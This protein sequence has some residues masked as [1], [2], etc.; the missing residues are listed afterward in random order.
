MAITALGF[1]IFA[2]DHVSETTKKV[3]RS[4]KQLAIDV[5]AANVRVE[6]ATRSLA[7]AETKFGKSSLEARDASVKL[8]QAQLRLNNSTRLSGETAHKTTGHFRNLLAAV[9]GLAITEGLFEFGKK[10]VEAF[11]EA[12]GAQARLSDA[13][14]KFPLL[15]NANIESFRQLNDELEKKTEADHNATAS[16]EATLAQFRL[17][18]TQV[19]NLTPLLVDYA[20]KTGKDLPTAA[21]D[22]GKAILGQGRALKGS[23]IAFHDTGTVAGNYAE[24]MDALKAKV[25]GFAVVQGK[26]A[27]GQVVIFQNRLHSLEEE[28][29][30]QLLPVLTATGGTL[31]TVAGF[32]DRNRKVIG[33]LV[34]G[35]GGLALAILAVNAAARATKSVGSFVNSI[36]SVGDSGP[37]LRAGLSSVVGFLGGPWGAALTVGGLALGL[38]ARK[39]S[40]ARQLVDELKN[41]LNQETGAITGVTRAVTFQTLEKEGLIKA[42]KDLG[43]ALNDVTDA[44]LGNPAA[45]ARVSAGLEQYRSHAVDVRGESG[46]LAREANDVGSAIGDQNSALGTARQKLKDMKAAGV[47]AADAQTDFGKDTTK[48]TAAIVDE[49]TASQRLRDELD[50]LTGKTVAAD[51]AQ[52]NYKDSVATLSQAFKDNGRS[53]DINSDKGRRNRQAVIDSTSAAEDYLVAL[54]DS[55]V[56]QNKVR[57][58]GISMRNELVKIVTHMGLTRAAAQRLIDKYLAIPPHV[59]TNVV[60]NTAAATRAVSIFTTTVPKLLQRIP[61]QGVTLTVGTKIVFPKDWQAFRAGEHK[62]LGGPVFGRG[63]PTDAAVPAMLS[64][65]EHVWTARE[66]AAA[67]GHAAMSG[68]R[69][70]ALSRYAAGGEVVNLNVA[71]RAGAPSLKWLE[72]GFSPYVTGAA[73]YIAANLHVPVP[74]VGGA[75]GAGV[76]RWGGAVSTALSALGMPHLWLA[77][78]LNRISRESGGNPT[79]VN[80]WD[81]N[82]RAGT[83]SVGLMQ[84]IGPTFRSYAGPF[85]GWPPFEYGVSTNPLANIFAGLNYASHRYGRGNVPGIMV[86]SGGYDSGGLLM[87]GLTLAYNGTGQPEAVLPRGRNAGGVT[88]VINA[89][90]YVGDKNDLVKALDDLRRQ[91]RLT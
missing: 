90:N 79:I 57:D 76:S 84:V 83:P 7:L 46:K 37:K 85:R 61:D 15:A 2:R 16:G 12:Q 54:R 5:Q 59:S 51:E 4:A 66:V 34:L 72:S 55:G 22:L 67:G 42:S 50:R 3:G 36:K 78:V 40:D 8:G 39:Q 25:G 19:R 30:G 38:W 9:G 10:S 43:L 6:K 13:F 52:I 81:S 21:T 18:G 41:S 24:I 77:A 60:A 70:A 27:G 31:L 20:Q 11:T 47:G 63:G 33:P 64:A 32:L 71:G 48:A 56:G 49:R 53:L 45:M 88:Y 68:M 86:R 44:A 1:D 69:R 62:A 80:R 73:R 65:G 58:T 89:P 17:T 28:I 82:W 26:T 14:R 75:G 87:P 91:R 35:L 29:G 74:F 23:G